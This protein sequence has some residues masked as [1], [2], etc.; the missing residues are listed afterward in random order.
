MNL[1]PTSFDWNQAKL[2]L[3]AVETGS[4]SAAARK[5]G[6]AQPTLSRQI[7]AL[8]QSLGV[9]LLERGHRALSL[10]QA[11]IELLEHVQTMQHAANRISLSA[12]GQSQAI[13]GS[14][15]ITASDAMACYRL[16]PM[17]KKLREIAP[18]IK[19]E[20]QASNEVKNL[21]RR[22]ADIAIRHVRPTQLDLITKLIKE[23]AAY[24]YAA[25]RYLD[26]IGHPNTAENV[27]NAAF[28]GHD[29]AERS[30]NTYSAFGLSLQ[31]SNI[32]YITNSG[33]AM[34]EMI[35]QGLGIGIMDEY[36][37]AHLE[38]LER[39]LPQQEP[40]RFPIWLTTHRE[41]HTNRRI[42]IVYDFLAEELDA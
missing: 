1:N 16:P 17:L 21:L 14:V 10:T 23:P 7:S 9:I 15:C 39:I 13:E 2:F 36:T 28:I 29:N 30:V 37:A 33:T 38:G 12:S 41:L 26:E 4:L 32:H 5:L 6:L 34:F 35:K 3:A 19:V 22:E 24:L 27:M 31:P 8:E 20:I 40:V 25:S 18:G 42:R 11:G